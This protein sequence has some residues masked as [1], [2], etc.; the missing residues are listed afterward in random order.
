VVAALLAGLAA[1]AYFAF[2]FEILPNSAY[3]KRRGRE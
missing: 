1:F 3:S 2:W